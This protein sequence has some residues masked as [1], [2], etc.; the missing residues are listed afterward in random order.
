M[1]DGVS[2]AMDD[3]WN[4]CLSEI[5]TEIETYATFTK[6]HPEE[7]MREMRKGINPTAF[8]RTA[9][10]SDR[11]PE[12]ALLF[13]ALCE[14]ARKLGRVDH[15][16]TPTIS[17]EQKAVL[18]KVW[19]SIPREVGVTCSPPGPGHAQQLA[20]KLRNAVR[21]L[22]PEAAQYFFNGFPLIGKTLGRVG[23]LRGYGNAIVP[24]VAAEFIKAFAD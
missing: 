23:L 14:L 21:K 11:L 6:T 17:E 18:R 20:G 7:I 13:A 8:Q 9:G 19:E 3:L 24:Q 1:A 2:T 22:P 15:R 5:K 4:A 16:Q 12:A 10:G